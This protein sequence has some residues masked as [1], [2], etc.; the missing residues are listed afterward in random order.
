MHELTSEKI[1]SSKQIKLLLLIYNI[2]KT[3][4]RFLLEYKQISL[5][6]SPWRDV[7]FPLSWIT[8]PTNAQFPPPPK[9]SDYEAHLLRSTFLQFKL[10]FPM[11]MNQYHK[12]WVRCFLFKS[13]SETIFAI[14]IYTY[15]INGL[16]LYSIFSAFH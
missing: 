13:L 7:N 8:F 15:C 3:Q 12:Y 14:Q 2:F 11:K 16:S 5:P 6:P 1:Q 10:T 9:N 4:L